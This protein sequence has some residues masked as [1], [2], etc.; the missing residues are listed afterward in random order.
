LTGG[1]REGASAPWCWRPVVWGFGV[2]AFGVRGI[3]EP[4]S[5][6]G[7]HQGSSW[8]LPLWAITVELTGLP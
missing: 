4:G 1:R 3:L 5:V 8:V 6:W 7:F 2:W